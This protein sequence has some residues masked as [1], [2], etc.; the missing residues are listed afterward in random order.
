VLISAILIVNDDQ[1]ITSALDQL[2]GQTGQSELIVV[3]GA[4]GRSGAVAAAAGQ[5]S[6]VS[7]P[8]S[9]MAAC[10][11]A[12]AAVATGDVLLFVLAESHVPS[13]ATLAIE[14]NLKLLPQTVGG[15]FHLKFKG[16][17][18]LAKILFYLLKWW[19]YRGSYWAET[20]IFVRSRAF[21]ELGGFP[22][23]SS[24]ADLEFVRRLEQHG[25]TLYLPETILGPLPSPQ[26]ALA[27]LTGPV[28]MKLRR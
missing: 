20:G 28:L 10:F 6:S 7:R 27:W 24:L 9:D 14:R 16:N 18:L 13:E 21:E 23:A 22:T 11:N 19:R 17:A 25:P 3:D 15:N 1:D 12:G 26:R 4:N 2:A 5:F 8:A